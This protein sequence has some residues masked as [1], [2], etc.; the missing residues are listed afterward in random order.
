[1]LRRGGFNVENTWTDSHCWFAVSLGVI[2]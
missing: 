2:I 1:L